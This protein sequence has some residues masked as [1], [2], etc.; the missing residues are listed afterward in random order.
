ML[1][2]DRRKEEGQ[3]LSKGTALGGSGRTAWTR[4]SGG[5]GDSEGRQDHAVQLPPL[6]ALSSSALA[7]LFLPHLWL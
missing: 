2:F 6:L 7:S 4:V 5:G 3:L 1:T